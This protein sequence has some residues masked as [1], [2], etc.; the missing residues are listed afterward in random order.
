MKKQNKQLIGIGL[1]I[2]AIIVLAIYSK[3][4]AIVDS[5]RIEYTGAQIVNEDEKGVTYEFVFYYNGESSLTEEHSFESVNVNLPAN[6]KPYREGDSPNYNNEIVL[7]QADAS[8]V[9]LIGLKAISREVYPVK[10]V[11]VDTS[12]VKAK[13]SISRTIVIN[14]QQKAGISCYFA[15]DVYPVD[16][17]KRVRG[18]VWGLS[19]GRAIITFS[20]SQTPQPEPEMKDV[21]VYELTNNE[22]NSRIVPETQ[23]SGYYLSYDECQEKIV[24]PTD[25]TPTDGETPT[26]KPTD[27]D[28]LIPGQ[29]INWELYLG[30]GVG[31]VLIILLILYFRRRK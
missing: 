17:G 1:V 21:T 9:N 19:E 11:S 30:I 24:I 2:L 3:P 31:I 18:D 8:Y 16:G 23:T 22:C 25:E 15:G 27:G 7:T 13:C 14:N 5:S 28:G 10:E 26:D 6:W 29:G 20:K 4:L 12:E